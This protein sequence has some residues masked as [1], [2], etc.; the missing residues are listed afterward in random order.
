MNAT[1]RVFGEN[2]QEDTETERFVCFLFSDLPVSLSSCSKSPFD[3]VDFKLITLYERIID[4]G[5]DRLTAL[6]TRANALLHD[7]HD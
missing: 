5:V 1:R 6:A 2:E 4:V 3:R 7:G